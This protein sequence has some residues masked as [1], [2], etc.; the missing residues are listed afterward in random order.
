MGRRQRKRRGNHASPP[1][2]EATIEDDEESS[3]FYQ[4]EMSDVMGRY[5]V[6]KSDIPAGTVIL[7]ENPLV[8]GPSQGTSPICIACYEPIQ[9]STCA[10]CKSCSWPLCRNNCQA[11][12]NNYGHLQQEC[13]ILKYSEVIPSSENSLYNV[14]TP[15]RVLLLKNQNETEWSIISSMEA[16]QKF[17][18]TTEMWKS[19]EIIINYVKNNTKLTQLTEDAVHSVCGYIQVN[20]FGVEGKDVTAIF[21][22]AFLLSH[23]CTP[24]TTHVIDSKFHL[25]IRTTIPIKKGDPLTISYCN[26]L[27]G[28]MWRREQLLGSKF[29]DCTCKRCSDKTEFNTFMSAIKC[30]NCQNGY[31]LP[32]NPLYNCSDWKC[33]KCCNQK[34]KEIIYNFINRL[35]EEAEQLTNGTVSDNEKFLLTQQKYLHPNHF[36]LLSIK[37]KLSQ[38]YGKSHDCII[39]NMTEDQ[40][41]RK[42]NICKDII[43]ILDVIEPGLSRI[44][45]ITLYEIHA[46]TFIL[47]M[48]HFKKSND[49]RKFKQ[50]IKEVKCLL[51]ESTTILNIEDPTSKEGQVGKAAADALKQMES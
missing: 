49:K 2:N 38:L 34:Q 26:T 1:V 13:E 44:R 19:D 46:P 42:I 23:D 12:G 35:F 20:G 22:S 30:E 32:A 39:H 48:N 27:H 37:L 50:V 5:L 31:L 41:K 43:K 10:R 4:I 6:A 33:D 36:V 25:T 28:S 17:R 8:V 3:Q 9:L 18:Q 29:F 45:G 15:L 16:H 14:L 51:H 47:G 21:P 40:L 24:N 7:E 11:I